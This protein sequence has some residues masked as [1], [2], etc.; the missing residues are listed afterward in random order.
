MDN[1]HD[2]LYNDMKG[3]CKVNN[4]CNYIEH[5]L[6][7]EI[8]DLN[9]VSDQYCVHVAE[10]NLASDEDLLTDKWGGIKLSKDD[11]HSMSQ[12]IRLTKTTLIKV[13]PGCIYFIIQL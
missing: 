2:G 10:V 11:M 1:M 5:Q 13:P 7:I 9:S 8:I 4:E 6:N 12:T 3:K